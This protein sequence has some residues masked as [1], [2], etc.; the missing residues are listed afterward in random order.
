MLLVGDE[1][2]GSPLS[3]IASI[4]NVN[5]NVSNYK[6]NTTSIVSSDPLQV[7]FCKSDSLECDNYIEIETVR[8][9]EFTLQA[10]I[11]G[12]GFGANPSVVRVSLD[13]DA[14]L[15][16]PAQRIQPTGKT[17]TN[18]TYRLF[19]VNKT[20]IARLFPND[21]PC[22]DNYAV[23]THVTFLPC[24][25]GFVQNGPE[26][27]CDERLQY[28]NATCNV[29]NNS[30]QWTT[31]VFW[32]G[33]LYDDNSTYEG[34]ILHSGCPFDYC[35]DTPVPI[36]LDNLDI[37]CNHNH[38]G[39]LCGSCR[40]GYSI[41]LGALHCLP[42][43]NDYLALILPF[44]LAGIALVAILLLLKLTVTAGTINGLIFYANIVQANGSFFF[45]AGETNI[46]TVFIAWL[47]LDLGIET[48]FYDGMTT[49]A[50]TWL[51]FVFP[52]YVWFLIGLI[53]VATTIQAS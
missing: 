28:F 40:E 8:G 31:S 14:Q 15:G 36:T 46:L 2:L 47:N 45:P 49:Y 5:V 6:D 25:N 38:S 37:Q 7:C 13:N 9:R 23:L 24:P 10:V 39:T 48:C 43:S 27:V 50:Y 42:C 19:A 34:L 3:I 16:S 20:T 4:S 1:M 22:R 32:V 26:C 29:D 18:I 21:S 53:I 30:I 51:Q 44:S 52:F 41:A 33:V 35:V 17:C 12:Q 11:V